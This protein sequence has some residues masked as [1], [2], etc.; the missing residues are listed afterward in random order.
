MQPEFVFAGESLEKHW[1][2][3]SLGIFNTLSDCYKAMGR[4]NEALDFLKKCE[5]VAKSIENR[6]MEAQVRLH[7]PILYAFVVCSH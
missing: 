5:D 3:F 1:P 6:A 4:Y 2:N 7:C